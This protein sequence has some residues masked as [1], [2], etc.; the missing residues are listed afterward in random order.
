MIA[1]QCRVTQST[2]MARSLTEPPR[3]IVKIHSTPPG[4]CESP[5]L[6]NRNRVGTSV[7]FPHAS[8]FCDSVG[9]VNGFGATGRR[10]SA[11]GSTATSSASPRSGDRGAQMLAQVG[12][13]IC[14]SA[15]C[16]TLFRSW[17]ETTQLPIRRR[18][19]LKARKGDARAARRVIRI[20]GNPST[21]PKCGQRARAGRLRR[22]A[23]ACRSGWK[24]WRRTVTTT[25]GGGDRG[26]C[27]E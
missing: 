25:N 19:R 2:L 24:G 16:G 14:V 22:R 3:H 12:G 6:P 23:S 5:L 26:L 9:L 17:Q 21:F 15:G 4:K 20:S 1:D 7:I 13:N 18:R 11:A 8:D 27:L 10:R